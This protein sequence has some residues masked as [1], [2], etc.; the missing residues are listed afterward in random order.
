[1]VVFI[2]KMYKMWIS[3]VIIEAIA[4]FHQ[5]TNQPTGL[6]LNKL[7]IVSISNHLQI[8]PCSDW[9]TPSL[10]LL[11]LPPFAR[12]FSRAAVRLPMW[13]RARVSHSG[14][15]SGSIFRK[16]ARHVSTATISEVRWKTF[17]QLKLMGCLRRRKMHC[18]PSWVTKSIGPRQIV[19]PPIFSISCKTI[20]SVNFSQCCRT[21]PES[22]KSTS[23]F[24]CF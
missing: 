17:A 3:R 10:F 20:A 21:P 12:F 2:G 23:A 5:L 15:F 19:V 8:P 1:M 7:F 6:I 9:K 24:V 18:L 22:I 14:I 4:I 13:V 16:I 11:A